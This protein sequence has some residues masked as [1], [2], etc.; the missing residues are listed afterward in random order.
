MR[1]NLKGSEW[2]VRKNNLALEF[3]AFSFYIKYSSDM[4]ELVK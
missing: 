2:T 1:L 3:K 4:I